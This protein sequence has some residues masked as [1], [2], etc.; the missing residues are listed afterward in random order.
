MARRRS[1]SKRGG[2][3]APAKCKAQLKTCMPT[4]VR[5]GKTMSQA[6]RVCMKQFNSCRS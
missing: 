1:K 2:A 5:A 4:N 6:G 3:S